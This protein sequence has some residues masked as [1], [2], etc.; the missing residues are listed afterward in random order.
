[1]EVSSHGFYSLNGIGGANLTNVRLGKGKFPLV[2]EHPTTKQHKFDILLD[3][4][5][6]ER[7]IMSTFKD[8]VSVQI[9][10][11]TRHH[12]GTAVGMMGSFHKG[13]DHSILLARD[14]KARL[15]GEYNKLGQEWQVRPDE[16]MLFQS[17]R[18]PQ[19]FKDEKC[20]LPDANVNEIRRRR[21]LGEQTVSR[22][23]A[24]KACA[25]AHLSTSSSDKDRMEACIFDVIAIGDV[26]I[27]M[28]GAY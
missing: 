4:D 16:P 10:N 15:E 18:Y 20:L 19:S 17:V 23:D 22:K 5:H 21:R 28:A 27:A 13:Q 6:Q 3:K 7:I 9:H 2:Y 11:G 14:G 25:H 26:E 12:F 8:L 1:M 24:E